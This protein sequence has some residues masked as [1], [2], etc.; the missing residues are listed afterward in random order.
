MP[1]KSIDTNILVYTYD[2]SERTKFGVIDKDKDTFL[3]AIDLVSKHKFIYGMLLW[4]L[5]KGG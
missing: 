1:D 5:Y 2:T 4:C 3:S